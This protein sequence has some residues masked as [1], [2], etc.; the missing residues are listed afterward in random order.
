[1]RFFLCSIFWLMAGVYSLRAQ[2][3]N[4]DIQ[5][6]SVLTLNNDYIE[7]STSH[8]TVEWNCINKSLRAATHKCLIYHN[9]QWFTFR[10]T[11]S[12]KYYLNIA[13]QKCRD[14]KGIQAIIVAGNPCQTK[15]YTIQHCIAQIRGEDAFI[16]LDSIQAD[17]DYFVNIDGFLGDFCNFKIQLSTEPQG[18]P[19]HYQNLDTLG[20]SANVMGKT[21]HLQWT[22]SEA[23]QQTLR[24]FEI[25]RSQ[26]SI[27]KSTLVGRIQ[28]A[29]NT[30]GTYT[31]SYSTTDTL[32]TRGRYTYEV[33]GVSS[34][35]KTK[36]VLD[37]QFIE[38]RPSSGINPFI[39]VALVYKSGTK[40]QLLLIDEIQDVILKQTSF[41]YEAKRDAN[42]KINVGEYLDRGITKFLVVSTNLK[43]FEK[44][45]YKFMLSA[46]SRMKLV[47]E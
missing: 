7:S 6:G 38:Y 27:R 40:V 10:V 45:V 19:H 12:G 42:Q 37:R 21:V 2:V 31:T 32:A 23:L 9:D 46:D 36:Q 11:K 8:A 1:M 3:A 39:D 47:V 24:E 14:E 28:I 17:E 4:N 33:V 16:T 44:R 30:I 20:L 35:N 26:Q 15:N 29:L 34:E 22:T 41:V 25:Y 43:T 18:F 5:H 13:S